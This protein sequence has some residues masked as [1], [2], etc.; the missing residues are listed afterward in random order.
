MVLTSRLDVAFQVDSVDAVYEEA[1]HN[2][3]V[4]VQR[5]MTVRDEDGEVRIATIKTYGDTVHTLVQNISYKGLFLPGYRASTGSKDPLSKLLPDIRLEA[6]DHCVGNQ[7]WDQM[8]S[9]CD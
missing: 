4:S 5:P 9:V 1:I 7:D 2:G 6:I 8:E 3:A